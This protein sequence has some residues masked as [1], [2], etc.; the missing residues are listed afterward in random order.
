M[1]G[2]GGGLHLEPKYLMTIGKHEKSPL[3]PTIQDWTFI[4][5]CDIKIGRE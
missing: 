3:I 2:K 1:E 5:L 4:R